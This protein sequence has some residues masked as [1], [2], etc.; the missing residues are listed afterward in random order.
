M[1]QFLIDIF[2]AVF[3]N[4][5]AYPRAF[6][7]GVVFL[8]LAVFQLFQFEDFPAIIEY[9]RLPG[10]LIV[11]WSLAVVLP[12]LEI[13]ALPY[14]FSMR[15]ANRVRSLSK[16][17]GAVVAGLW[18]AITTWTSLTMGMTVESGIFG[19][20]LTTSSGW[21]S[22]LFAGLLVWSY[23]LTVR[24]LPPRLAKWVKG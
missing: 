10:G 7:L 3:R 21:W 1:K 9:M 19:A 24:E 15:L 18:L 11:A 22:V 14:L 13:V 23:F 8:L 12:L 6:V 4:N 2:P 16:W 5:H 17:A 20:T